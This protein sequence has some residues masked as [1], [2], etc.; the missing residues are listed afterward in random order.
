MKIL[1]PYIPNKTK[2]KIKQ[3]ILSTYESA[4]YLFKKGPLL[5]KKVSHVVFVC[6]GNVCRSAFAEYFM[7]SRYLG[8]SIMIESCGL[9]V[10]NKVPSPD[11]AIKIG[12]ELGVDLVSHQSKSYMA[13]DL[14]G[15]N[16]ILPMEY[17]QYVQLLE[18]FP[19][20]KDKIYLLNHFTPWPQRFNIN[21]YDPYGS[22][23]TEFVSCFRQIQLAIE[24][25]LL[26][27]R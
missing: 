16:L 6:K 3:V 11:M 22:G 24:H 9:N 20:Y 27:I 2:N 26:A 13:C 7:R 19:E 12:H 5:K 4:I 10:E 17:P 14:A 1:K 21:I 25:L 18:L 15:A 8:D 23:K